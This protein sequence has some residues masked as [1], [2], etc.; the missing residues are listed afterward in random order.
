[1]IKTKD[2][3]KQ[4]II[5]GKMKKIIYTMI[6]FAFSIFI[7]QPANAEGIAVIEGNLG[8]TVVLNTTPPPSFGP[9]VGNSGAHY[10]FP[11]VNDNNGKNGGTVRGGY[12]TYAVVDT[13]GS[14]TNIIVCELYCSNGTVG[15]GGET[16]VL[17]VPGKDWGLW[18]G[19]NTTTYDRNEKKFTAINPTIIET[20][21]TN[22]DE[23]GNISVVT[24]SGKQVFTFYSENLFFSRGIKTDLSFDS[25]ASISVTN[26]NTEFL[27]LE[28]RKSE[29]E[30]KQII[31]DS[32][33]L[34]LNSKVET[35][36]SLLGSW[37]K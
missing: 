8:P 12:G 34:L 20:T 22:I 31:Q 23:Q 33:L 36:I 18:F 16:A 1:M 24:V 21:S 27:N 29:I 19:P 17:Q 37:V 35:L 9:T 2:Y 11:T 10:N 32:D 6:L 4:N 26:N 15:P 14:V 5:R 13:N 3:T 25:K 30:I 28:N 7:V